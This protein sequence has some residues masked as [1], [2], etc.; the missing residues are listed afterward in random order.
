MMN[1]KLKDA[2]LIMTGQ[3]LEAEP[4][5]KARTKGSKAK[6]KKERK[7]KNEVEDKPVEKPVRKDVASEDAK[8]A[9]Y[10]YAHNKEQLSADILSTLKT[11]E[12]SP[13]LEKLLQVLFDRAAVR[14]LVSAQGGVRAPEPKP[15]EYDL[16]YNFVNTKTDEICDDQAKT[17]L[18]GGTKIEELDAY[19]IKLKVVK[20]SK[21]DGKELGEG[22]EDEYEEIKKQILA[23]LKTSAA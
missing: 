5:K 4:V 18:K 17:L 19:N 9:A 14:E 2:F 3:D 15:E 12:L 16:S 7:A 1:R 6:D 22:S 11:G 8:F 23:D 13:E 20:K 10:D 21:T